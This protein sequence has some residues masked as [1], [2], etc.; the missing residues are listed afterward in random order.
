M[1]GVDVTSCFM[2]SLTQCAREI[3]RLYTNGKGGAGGGEQV[4]CGI[5]ENHMGANVIAG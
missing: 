1:F 4:W 2:M 5:C 3:D